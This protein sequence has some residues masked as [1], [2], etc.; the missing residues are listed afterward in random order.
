M[1]TRQTMT[2][3]T[4]T[5]IVMSISCHDPSGGGG[6]SADIETLSS[7]GCHCTPII[8]VLAA[9][10]TE[11]VKD[12]QITDTALL[13]GQIRSV[14]EDIPVD[15]IKIGN[16]ASIQN[17]EAMHTILNDYPEIPVV[18]D[19][20]FDPDEGEH[21]LAS[22]IRNLL[23]SQSSITVLNET[24]AYQ[25]A[26]GSDSLAACIQEL[27][28]FGCSQILI[29][30]AHNGSDSS[31]VI[32][33]LFSHRGLNQTYEWQRLPHR[34]HGA[35]CTLTAALSAYLAHQLSLAESVQQAQ[36]FTWQ[37]MQ[38]GR[39]LGM[40]RLIPDRLHWCSQR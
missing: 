2:E 5:P 6:I 28:E 10:D 11:S 31:K 21:G 1:T 18:L 25:L 39:R 13:I 7:L 16:L 38:E 26:P 14:L 12:S 30:D 33:K 15:L 22:A 32:N 17:T 4:H 35:G 3:L 19:P 8:S 23:L 40:G 34:Y 29:T 9:Q 20:V 36:K 37:A 27:L 24:E